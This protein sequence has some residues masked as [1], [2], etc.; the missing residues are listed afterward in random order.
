MAGAQTIDVQEKHAPHAWP[1][2]LE[3][4]KV[5]TNT[6]CEPHQIHTQE[7]QAY[8]YVRHCKILTR[9]T[10]SARA[11]KHKSNKHTHISGQRAI[12]EEV[13]Q[14][15]HH[16][17][18]ACI[19]KKDTSARAFKHKSNKRTLS[20]QRALTISPLSSNVHFCALDPVKGFS[21]GWCPGSLLA[22]RTLLPAL[23]RP[24]RRGT[25][26]LSLL[27]LMLRLQSTLR[28]VQHHIAQSLECSD[29]GEYATVCA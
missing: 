24:S 21:V 9:K 7:Q 23:R 16:V 19:D 22:V 17:W 11:S 14:Q 1:T 28:T 15:A 25:A 13:K 2:C 3:G 4:E 12:W 18:P 6:N 8:P 26:Q 27:L 20:G 5:S 29:A 10:Q